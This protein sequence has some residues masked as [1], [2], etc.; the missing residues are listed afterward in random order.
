MD[1]NS[2]PIALLVGE[3]QDLKAVVRDLAERFPKNSKTWLHP[4]EIAP[5]LGV[6]TR[7]LKAWRDSGRIRNSS[8]RKERGGYVFHRDRVLNDL[9]QS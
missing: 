3:L 6:S 5:M 8:Y 9:N 1:S 7:T 4:R 2:F